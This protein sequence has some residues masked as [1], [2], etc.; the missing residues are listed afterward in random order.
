MIG[1]ELCLEH[2]FYLYIV[3][4]LPLVLLALLGSFPGREGSEPAAQGEPS[5]VPV[6]APPAF[7][8]LG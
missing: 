8:G 7:A 1:V 3:W 4:F 2:W 5:A 6:A